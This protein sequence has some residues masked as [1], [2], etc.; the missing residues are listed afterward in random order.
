MTKNCQSV[1]RKIAGECG[2]NECKGKGC[3]MPKGNEHLAG[4]GLGDDTP[5]KPIEVKKPGKVDITAY[6]MG[7]E[8]AS[9]ALVDALRKYRKAKKA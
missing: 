1:L 7:K 9:K 8:P 4:L 2:H 3:E 5:E 6:G